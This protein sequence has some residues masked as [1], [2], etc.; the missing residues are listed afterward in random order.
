[1]VEVAEATLP[2]PSKPDDSLTIIDNRTGQTYSVPISHNAI[3]ALDLKQI[4]YQ[5][6]PDGKNPADQHEQGLRS[7]DPGFQNTACMH[8]EVTFV[9]GEAGEIS[10]RGI[11]VPELYKSGRSYEEVAFLLIF[12]NLPSAA[13]VSEFTRKIAA[14]PLPPQ[15]IFDMIKALP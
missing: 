10:Y 1:M 9:D 15:S 6:I 12:G 5:S 3:R 13:E 7:L 11:S 4:K 2:M 8:S 14:S